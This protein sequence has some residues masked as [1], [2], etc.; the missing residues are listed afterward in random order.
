MTEWINP[1]D[2]KFFGKIN[3]P[4]YDHSLRVSK[5]INKFPDLESYNLDKDI[6][7]KSALLH[8]VGKANFRVAHEHPQFSFIYCKEHGIDD[9]ISNVVLLHHQFQNKAYPCLKLD[10]YTEKEI[11]HS[12]FLSCI[13]NLDART[14]RSGL[15]MD[16]IS[17]W[18][19]MGEKYE[20]EP[21]KGMIDSLFNYDSIIN[22][23]PYLR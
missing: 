21:I 17:L 3:Q 11:R 7:F 1:Y 10:K 9:F 13:D 8:D 6:L 23:I 4:E 2:I 12:F 20:F 16:K 22:K 18:S 5:I 14:L 19:M 15:K